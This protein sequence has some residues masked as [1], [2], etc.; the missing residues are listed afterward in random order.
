VRRLASLV[1]VS[2]LT[3]TELTGLALWE[4]AALEEYH[5]DLERMRNNRRG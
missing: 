4:L 1:N 3:W 2:G 5:A